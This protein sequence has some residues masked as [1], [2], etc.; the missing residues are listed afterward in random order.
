MWATCLVF[1]QCVLL[2][3]YL[4]AHFL[5]RVLNRRMQVLVHVLVLSVSAIGAF[6]LPASEFYRAV[7]SSPSLECLKVLCRNVGIPYFVLSSTT[8]LLQAWY[9]REAGRGLPYRLFALSNLGSLIA[10]M[11]YPFVIERFWGLNSQLA[12]WRGAYLAFV[13]L[14]CFIGIRVL[15][16][17]SDPPS[18][19]ITFRDECT[20]TWHRNLAWIALAACSS[21]LLLGVTNTLCQNVAPI[22]LLWIVPL[23]IYLVT[24]V[25]CFDHDRLYKPA[26]FQVLLPTALVVLVWAEGNPRKGVAVTSAIYLSC[27]FV[28]CMFCHGQLS[29]MKPASRDL[30]SFYLCLSFGGA[31]G[32]VFVGLLAPALFNDFFELKVAVCACLVLSLRFLF[33]YRSKPFLLTC[34]VVAIVGLRVFANMNG[35]PETFHQRNFYG[36]LAIWEYKDS[37][38]NRVRSLFHGA[39]LHG[40]QILT[41]NGKLEPTTYY[42]RKSGVG[43]ALQRSATASRVGII[44]L[45]AGTI[46]AYGRAGDYYRFYELNPLVARVADSQFSYLRDSKADVGVSIGDGRLS[47]EGEPDEHFDTLILDAFSGDSIPVHLLTKEA[48]ECYFRHL[49][50]KGV[51]AVHITNQYVDLRSVI[52]DIA[53]GFGRRALLV[54]SSA[55]PSHDVMIAEWVLITRDTAFLEQIRKTRRGEFISPTQHRAWTDQYSNL[56]A[57]LR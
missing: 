9:A 2:L 44:G 50:S 37:A 12:T 42:G 4:Y 17:R 25:L 46:A 30:T 49:N 13:L 27:L 19:S 45:G 28:I 18:I 8:P 55:E 20:E 22:P 35:I 40:T 54:R 15:R 16:Y 6:V 34:A 38:R 21:A 47:L 51:L 53:A 31:L 36:V 33:G 56:L 57:V 24:F 23:T 5:I 1:F 7:A 14:C 41:G 10:L 11:A 48:F 43:M 32:G 3:G 29:R 39:C 52:A 26:A